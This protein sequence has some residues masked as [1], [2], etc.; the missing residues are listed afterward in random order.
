VRPLSRGNHTVT[1]NSDVANDVLEEKNSVEKSRSD[2]LRVLHVSKTVK[3]LD[4]KAV[5]YQ[6]CYLR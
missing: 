3:G 6:G 4:T 1:E 2:F 5:K